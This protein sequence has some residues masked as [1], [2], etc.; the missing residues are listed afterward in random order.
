[1]NNKIYYSTEGKH[2]RD[3]EQD[4]TRQSHLLWRNSTLNCD[5][6]I[7]PF[8]HQF[9]INKIT[10]FHKNPVK[11]LLCLDKFPNLRIDESGVCTQCNKD[12]HIKKL[13]GMQNNMD[14]GPIT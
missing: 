11:F 4:V 8:Y 1:M 10:V 7:P 9:V 6:E 5:N 3:L 2:T 12:K 14:P 13:Y